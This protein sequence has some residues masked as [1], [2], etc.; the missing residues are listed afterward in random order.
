MTKKHFFIAIL[1][2]FFC[3]NSFSQT[4]AKMN[5]TAYPNYQKADKQLNKVYKQLILTLDK[6]ESLY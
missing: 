6:N 5:E 3:N 1:L 2:L 4:Q